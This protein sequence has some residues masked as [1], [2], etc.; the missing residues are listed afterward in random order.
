MADRAID[1]VA[2]RREG[3]P[4]TRS[5]GSALAR[6][7]SVVYLLMQDAEAQRRLDTREAVAS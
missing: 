6:Q 2:P 5:I 1:R 4:A 3:G 7:R